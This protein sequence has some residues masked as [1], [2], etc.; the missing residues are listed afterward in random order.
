MTPDHDIEIRDAIA[1]E[2]AHWPIGSG[3]YQTS[4]SSDDA[5]DMADALMSDAG[6]IGRLLAQLARANARKDDARAYGYGLTNVIETQIRLAREAL[7]K[8][9]GT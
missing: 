1:D 6:P 7:D 5:N 2:L 3:Y 8:L 9:S 4:V